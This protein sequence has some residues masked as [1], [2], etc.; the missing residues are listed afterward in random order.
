LTVIAENI[1]SKTCPK[2][3]KLKSMSILSR[4]KSWFATPVF[5]GE[6]ENTRQAYLINLIVIAGL[7]MA[8]AIFIILPWLSAEASFIP[9]LL[10]V[11]TVFTSLL[12][13]KFILNQG[14]VREAGLF[15]TTVLWLV[16]ATVTLRGEEG[17]AGTPFIGAITL[18]PLIAGFVSGVR[19]SVIITLLNWLL[20]G[21][22]VWLEMS[23]II[24]NG[25]TYD[26]LVRYFSSMVMFSAFPLLI[27][28]WRRN[29]I[30]AIEQ[31]RVA[32]QAQ[33]ETAAYRLQN[34]ELEIAVA[35]R[36]SAL[37]ESLVREQHMAEKLALALEF[38]TQLG[39][40]QSR[41]ITVVSHEFRTPLSIIS[42][43]S[44]LLQQYYERL[45]RER[46]EA[47]HERIRESV[48]Y[49]NDLLKDVTWVDKAQRA[50]IRPS[51][52]TYTFSDLCQKLTHQLARELNEPNR[53]R[54]HF[55]PAIETPV[56]IDLALLEQ[57]LANLVSNGLKYSEKETDV[58]VHFWLDGTQLFIEVQDQGIGVP[59]HEQGRIF[60]LFYRA[61]NVDERRGLGLG[62]F[63]VQAVSK[64][65]QGSVRL[66]SSGD[67]QGATFEVR[68]PLLPELD[69]AA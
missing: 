16:F 18:V 62:L 61:S 19:A 64:W 30:E 21:L 38:E 2:N 49:L 47:A 13:T 29:F 37:E 6:E 52:Q 17:L 31:V 46:R 44:E 57:I 27:Y 1:S 41:I 8:P 54:F 56:Q 32:K 22:L 5:P 68:L 28:L 12:I 55:A 39:E 63:I 9:F 58:Q 3:L 36:T 33:Q 26:P 4:L 20:G 50:T 23:G 59:R 11:T 67:G 65:L 7:M 14:K 10:A 66:H 60:E 35:A 24:P 25:T 40:L 69:K 51:Y 43:S 15:L 34:E 53:V 42:S 45:P 48:F